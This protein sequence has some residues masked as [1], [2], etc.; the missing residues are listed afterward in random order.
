MTLKPLAALLLAIP[1][2]AFAG[3]AE[4]DFLAKEMD[5]AVQAS[6]AAVSKS[7]G[8]AV[9]FDIKA[10]SYSNVDQLYTARNF[11]RTIGEKA[12]GYCSDAPSKAAV[13]KLK[14]IEVVKGTEVVFKF[15]GG[16]GTAVTDDSSSPSWD[17]VAAQ[18]DK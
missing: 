5:P 13:C 11:V 9:K 10:D 2:V 12:P 18:V 14:T 15:A 17:M 7:C 8:C 6:T 3:K 16:K 4:R 1:M